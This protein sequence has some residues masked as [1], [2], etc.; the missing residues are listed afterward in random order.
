M[1]GAPD[2]ADRRAALCRGY[3][4]RRSVDPGRLDLFLLLRA[5]T[6]VGW[7]IDRLDEPGG[8][9]RSRRCIAAALDL[10]ETYVK[11]RDA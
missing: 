3:A 6:Y 4:N 5:L 10:A 7:I 9:E 2:F 11:R 8:A 1:I